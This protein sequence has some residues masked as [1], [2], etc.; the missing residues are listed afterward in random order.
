VNPY[1]IRGG[2]LAAFHC[3]LAQGSTLLFSPSHRGCRGAGVR[4]DRATTPLAPVKRRATGGGV[5]AGSLSESVIRYSMGYS[6]IGWRT[7]RDGIA[8]NCA[9][10][11]AGTSKTR[12]IQRG[13][14][15]RR[16]GEVR[17]LGETFYLRDASGASNRRR[18]T[19]A[20][21]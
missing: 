17:S 14:V 15:V 4:R 5:A 1:G 2:Q 16:Q 13:D 12:R 3:A 10:G 8:D 19:L 18:D 7:I 9:C 21:H 11:N 6:E 20:R